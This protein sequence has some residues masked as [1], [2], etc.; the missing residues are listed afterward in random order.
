MREHPRTDSGRPAWVWTSKAPGCR[1]QLQTAIGLMC[2]AQHW[3]QN[4]WSASVPSCMLTG[5]VWVSPFCLTDKRKPY[6]CCISGHSMK[7][8]CS[9]D[10]AS[11]Q[12]QKFWFCLSQRKLTFH[13]S[14]GPHWLPYFFRIQFEIVRPVF[15]T[16]P[17]LLGL[18][19]SLS[20][21]DGAALPFPPICLL[22]SSNRLLTAESRT[23]SSPRL[24]S[25]TDSLRMSCNHS[26]F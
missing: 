15:R 3:T 8:W 26:P 22:S 11:R 20:P 4:A 9:K 1:W 16:T 7:M 24:P 10:R 19:S 2:V 6:K 14:Q 5:T 21:G 25:R 23:V 18:L 12:L 13:A 17:S